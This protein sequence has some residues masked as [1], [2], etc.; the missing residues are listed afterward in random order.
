[1]LEA[2]QEVAVWVEAGHRVGGTIV[3]R[4]EVGKLDLKAIRD[5]DKVGGLDDRVVV[6]VGHCCA[7]L[8]IYSF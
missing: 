1:M 7:S 3:G 2:V 6:G 4:F 5:V 8:P